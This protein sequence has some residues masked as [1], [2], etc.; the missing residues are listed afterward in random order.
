[1]PMAASSLSL[2]VRKSAGPR[3]PVAMRRRLRRFL[4]RALTAAKQ[5]DA[6]LCLTLSDDAE[7]EALNRSFAGEDHATDVLSFGQ[8]EAVVPEGVKPVSDLLGD[9]IISVETAERQAQARG[10]S[11]EDELRHLAVHGLC[12]LLGYDHATPAEERVMFAYEAELR[13]AA[14]ASK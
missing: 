1:M 11:L 6:E 2:L 12:H 3:V 9:V 8:R 13:A 4:F 14:A 10:H 7:L 5:K